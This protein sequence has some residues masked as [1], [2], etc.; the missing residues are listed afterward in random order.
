MLLNIRYPITTYLLCVYLC[1]INLKFIVMKKILFL[2]VMLPMMCYG[3]DSLN[4]VDMIVEGARV[5]RVSPSEVLD[6]RQF[7]FSS[8]FGE[9]FRVT[10]Y[11]IIIKTFSNYGK[12]NQSISYNLHIHSISPKPIF[13]A[14]NAR[15]LLKKKNGSNIIL[16]TI[17]RDEDEIG[18]IGAL[19]STDYDISA[20]FGVTI[21]QLNEIANSDITKMR[22]EYTGAV[23]NVD[24]DDNKFSAFIKDAIKRIE[25]SEKIKDPFLEGF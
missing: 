7:T 17:S 21:A 1:G 2:L 12:N 4:V 18:S 13:I 11:P 25:E 6:H 14:K 3:Q 9:S 5:I 20:I 19:Y 16:R 10:M 22:I 24:F 23:K 8:R 15:I